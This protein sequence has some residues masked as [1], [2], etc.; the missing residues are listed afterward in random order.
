M[1]VTVSAASVAVPATSGATLWHRRNVVYPHQERRPHH[2]HPPYSTNTHRGHMMSGVRCSLL[3]QKSAEQ[4]AMEGE[5]GCFVHARK[6]GKVLKTETKCT[7]WWVDHQPRMLPYHNYTDHQ[8]CATPCTHVWMHAMEGRWA[9]LVFA[10]RRS[11][12][13]QGLL[14]P[15]NPGLLQPL[16]SVH[17][18]MPHQH[19]HSAHVLAV[20]HELQLLSQ[21]I[22]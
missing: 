11:K 17:T 18:I 2:H 22:V 16:P 20:G 4:S 15:L 10:H 21:S 7:L 1:R 9:G 12:Q 6:V 14:H 19:Q 8:R 13:T 5:G 3:V